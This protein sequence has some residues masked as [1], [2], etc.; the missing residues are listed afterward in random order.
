M[1]KLTGHLYI[2]P[3][4]DTNRK[5]AWADGSNKDFSGFII[6]FVVDF[7]KSGV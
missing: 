5:N 7:F 1:I 2:S 3:L 4:G 6:S